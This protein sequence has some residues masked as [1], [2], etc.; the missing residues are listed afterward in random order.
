VSYELEPGA[1]LGDLFFKQDD[2]DALVT[3]ADRAGYQVAIHAI[4]DR[5]V[6]QAQT[7]IERAL[8]G[9]PNDLRHRIEHNSIIR[10]EMLARYGQLG[11]LP[12]LY[13]MYPTCQPFGPP[14]AAEY[15]GWEWPW[16]ALLDANPGLPVAWQGDDPFFGRVRPLDDFYSLLTRNGV[17]EDGAVCE[18]PAWQKAHT[19]T[20]E[21]ALKMMT[22][23]A[24]YALYRESEL[25][26]LEPGK[27][28]DLL[29]LSQS[30]L[31]VETSEILDLEVWMTMIGGRVE[32][33][34][35]GKED[36]CP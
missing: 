6:E 8:Q 18:A 4:G 24:A 36:Y 21:E 1:G 35:P 17:D 20:A 33:C 2:L 28:A 30:P 7:A 5:A 26:S 13:G 11:I 25:G 23:G 3:Q 27:Y 9:R 10:P 31:A 29:I 19:I 14:P 15:Q 32:F 22:T 16:R 12:V 34:L